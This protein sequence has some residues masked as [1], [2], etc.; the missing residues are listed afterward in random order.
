MIDLLELLGYDYVEYND[1]LLHA[2]HYSLIAR[3]L[4]E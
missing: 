4:D 3:I 2:V 1:G